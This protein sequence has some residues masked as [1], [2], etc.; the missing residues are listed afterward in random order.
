MLQKAASHEELETLT[1]LLRDQWEKEG[2]NAE[3]NAAWDEKFNTMMEEARQTIPVIS[4]QKNYKKKWLYR[5]AAAAVLVICLG[6]SFFLFTNKN[7]SSLAGTES[8]KPKKNDLTP[9]RNTAV[10]TLADGSTIVLDNARNGELANQGN[11]KIV[12]LNDGQLTYNAAKENSGEVLYNT[13]TTPRGGQYKLALPDGTEVWLN[14]ASS[15]RYP[16]AFSGNERKVEITGEAY[17]EVAKDAAKPFKVMVNEME[18]QVLGTHFNI[19]SYSD[20][21]T[22]K[23]TLLEGSVKI[24]KGNDQKFLKPGQQAQLNNTGNIKVVN[25]VNVDAVMAWK[26]GY[27]SF[28]NT[29]MAS[30]MRQISRWYDVDIVYEGKI[31]DR[32]FGGEILRSSNASH[33]LKILEE[34]KV[35]FRIEGKKIIVLP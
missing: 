2:R 19:N 14:A 12:K 34:S 4:I 11:T 31:P 18:V 1:L 33:V 35:N 23:T 29:D 15:I 21:A 22:I 10:L 20:E 25:D 3:T 9:G 17:F 16:T 5:V 24:S 13:M 26:N 8:N 28:E 32:K 30:V 6:V 27:F 7:E